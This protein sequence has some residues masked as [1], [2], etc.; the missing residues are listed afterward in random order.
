MG[1]GGI[2]LLASVPLVAQGLATVAGTVK[3][4]D[5]E[6]IAKASVQLKNTGTGAVFTATSST[7]GAYSIGQVPAGTYDLTVPFPC[8]LYNTFAQ[9]GIPIAA[10]QTL[11]LNLPVGWGMNLGTV[12]DDPV[13]ILNDMRDKGGVPPGPAPRGVD[14]KP[15]LSGLWANVFDGAQSPPPPLLPAALEVFRKN[16]ANIRKDAPGNFCLPNSALPITLPFPYKF[17]QTPKVIVMLQEFDNPGYRQI[18]LDGRPHP[19]DWNP[20]WLGHST[21]KWEDRK[22]VV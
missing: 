4:P 1:L 10:G 6:A 3:N 17:I 5:G 15:D 19:K 9:R 16:A 14:G 21:G 13:T 20:A 8:C 2:L 18:F 22:S 7:R 11:Q 12:I